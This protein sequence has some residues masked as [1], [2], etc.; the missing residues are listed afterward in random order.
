M[1]EVG[2][3]VPDFTLDDQ[4]GNPHSLSN[5][6]GKKVLIYFYPKDMTPGCTVQAKG[7][8]DAMND[9]TEYNVQVLGISTD[10]IES[11]QKFAEKHD[12][13]F[14]LLADVNKKVV[15]AYG[16]WVEK[17]MFGNKYM[18]T[19]RDSFLIDEKGN[20]IRHFIKISPAKHVPEVIKAIKA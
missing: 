13:N 9:L 17:S 12:L 20:L 4:E 15:E 6:R 3:P 14:P 1:F 8:R 10:S 19:Q 18:G 2:K 16:V 7:V 5:Y 11:H